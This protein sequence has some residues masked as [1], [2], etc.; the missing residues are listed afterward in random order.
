MNK[1]PLTL[2]CW[3]LPLNVMAT[4]NDAIDK[5]TPDSRFTVNGDGTA[6]D[7]QTGLTW[8]RCSIGQ[9][10][11]AG[12]C[13]GSVSGHTW[14]QA[15]TLAKAHAFAGENDWRLPN[16]KELNSIVEVSCINPAINSVIFPNTASD[17][18]SSS[19]YAHDYDGAWNVNFYFGYDYYDNKN[20]DFHVR[21][22]RGGQ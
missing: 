14:Q 21:L 4:C 8:M 11:K 13:I 22:V 19:P 17:Y 10:W 16:I 15:L 12:S 7:K 6:T 3:L 20:D 9:T 5:S 2:L 18:W 1:I